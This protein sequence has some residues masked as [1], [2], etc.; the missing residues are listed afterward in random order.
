MKPNPGTRPTWHVSR[1]LADFGCVTQS[2]SGVSQH[3]KPMDICMPML[4]KPIPYIY[5]GSA[6]NF[7]SFASVDI[8]SSSQNVSDLPAGFHISSKMATN[9]TEALLEGPAL[10]PPPGV[11]PNFADPGG[12]HT[13]GYVVIILGG[14][15][16]TISVAVRMY[17]RVII[18][19][20]GIE[21]GKLAYTNVRLYKWCLTISRSINIGFGKYANSIL[22]KDGKPTVA[23]LFT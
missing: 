16:A 11:I 4:V 3:I 19:K 21:D 6:W 8:K 22:Q 20:I 13:V 7:C 5:S 14:T 2:Q 10:Q 12:N 23:T 18:K 1:T 9:N 17:S 15:L